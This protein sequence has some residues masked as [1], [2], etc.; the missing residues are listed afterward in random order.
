MFINLTKLFVPYLKAFDVMSH[1][2]M[3]PKI[4]EILGYSPMICWIKCNSYRATY[5]RHGIATCGGMLIDY[6]VKSCFQ[7]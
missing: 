4:K 2:L 3:T 7:Y 6:Q 1:P 5:H